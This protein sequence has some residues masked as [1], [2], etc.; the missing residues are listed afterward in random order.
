MKE[1][2]FPGIGP[3]PTFWAPMV[4]IEL[5]WCWWVHHLA[6]A[7]KEVDTESQGLMEVKSCAVLDLV[8]FNQFLSY[9]MAM[10]FL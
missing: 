4:G 1:W 9:S 3:P 5:S 7:N 2:G 8:G 6:Y 10:S